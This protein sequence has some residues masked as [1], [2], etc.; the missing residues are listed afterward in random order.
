MNQQEELSIR[1]N[2]I[3]NSIGSFTY[4]FAQWLLSLIIVRIS[5]DLNDVGNFALAISITNI[6][7]SLACFNVRPYLVSDVTNQ[8]KV[9]EYVTFRI[10]TCVLAFA[11]CL[12]YVNIFSYSWEQQQSVVL[13]MVFKLGEAWVDLLHSFE[14][15]ASRM[16]IGG[17]SLLIRGILS[18]FVFAGALRITRNL[19]MS[20]VCMGIVTIGFI[21][22][23]DM[24]KVRR[25]VTI[26]P[27]CSFQ[28]IKVLFIEFLPLT[29]ASFLNLFSMTYPRQVLEMYSGTELLG[30]YAT[31]ATPTIIIQVAAS[32]IF[33]PLLTTFAFYKP[34]NYNPSPSEFLR[35]FPLHFLATFQPLLSSELCENALGSLAV[36]HASL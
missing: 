20:I 10:V 31:I 16:D 24:Y 23:Y 12:V 17:I 3:W 15:K 34:D 1:Q 21:M 35:T 18:V 4:L 27:K 6:F 2:T 5:S 32:Y 22:L 13:Y 19:Q 25:F 28:R 9:N 11:L 7:F 26:I 36:Q 33:N 29:V 14:Q 8:F 30:I